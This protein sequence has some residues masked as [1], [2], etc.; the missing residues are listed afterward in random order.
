MEYR[1]HKKKWKYGSFDVEAYRVSVEPTSE[2]N[3]KMAN[4]ISL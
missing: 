2:S 1:E 3:R 4:R